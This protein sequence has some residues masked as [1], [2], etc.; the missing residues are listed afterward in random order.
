[1]TAAHL[2]RLVVLSHDEI[3]RDTHVESL[4]MAG[5]DGSGE[6]SNLLGELSPP[7]AA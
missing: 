6:R 2:P 5:G 4:G 7:L 1:M 3:A